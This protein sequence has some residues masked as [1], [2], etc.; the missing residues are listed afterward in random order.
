MVSS[1][2]SDEPVISEYKSF[3]FEEVLIKP[4]RYED[5]AAA[6]ARLLKKG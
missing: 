5:M 3:G 2:Y 4:Y 6:L 1:G